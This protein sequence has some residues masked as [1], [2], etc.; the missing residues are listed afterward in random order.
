MLPLLTVLVS[1]AA[2]PPLTD[3][4]LEQLKSAGDGSTRLDEGALYPLLQNALEWKPGDETGAMVPDYLAIQNDPDAHRGQLFL[5]EGWFFRTLPVRRLAR[6]GPWM[7]NLQ[8]WS[9]MHNANTPVEVLIIDGP[10]ERDRPNRNQRVRLAGRFFKIWV[11]N[12]QDGRP[13]LYP[14]F[15]GRWTPAPVAG[16]GNTFSNAIPNPVIIAVVVLAGAFAATSIWRYRVN[17]AFAERRAR[18][19]AEEE[20]RQRE[21]DEQPEGPPL[22][23]DPTEAM[24]ELE[25]RQRES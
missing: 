1:L 12:D 20:K 19:I 13:S 5:I 9:L 23:E 11:S 18:E 3:A 8:Q 22:P 24:K 10:N 21:F 2:I 25:R 14:V 4:Q 6:D 15:V 16:G 7:K 17:K